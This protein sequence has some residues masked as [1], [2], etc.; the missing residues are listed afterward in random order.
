MPLLTRIWTGNHVTQSKSDTGKNRVLLDAETD[1]LRVL[2]GDEGFCMTSPSESSSSSSYCGP[3]RKMIYERCGAVAA[4]K[5][6]TS[7]SFFNGC[8]GS[9]SSSKNQKKQPSSSS[10]LRKRTAHQEE[11]LQSLHQVQFPSQYDPTIPLETYAFVLSINDISLNAIGMEKLLQASAVSLQIAR[12]LVFGEEEEEDTIV[13]GG[14]PCCNTSSAQHLRYRL[15]GFLSNDTFIPCNHPHFPHSRYH[16]H[17]DSGEQESYEEEEEKG[18]DETVDTEDDAGIPPRISNNDSS[19]SS[20]SSYFGY[21][22]N[23][24]PNG[25][26]FGVLHLLA[27]RVITIALEQVVVNNSKKRQ[28]MIDIK[29]INFLQDQFWTS[30]VDTLRNNLEMLYSDKITYYSLKCLRLLTKLEP[31]VVGQM[32]HFSLLPYLIYTTY[33]YRSN[34]KGNY[35]HRRHYNPTSRVRNEAMK[36]LQSTMSISAA[37]IRYNSLDMGS[38]EEEETTQDDKT[39]SDYDKIEVEEY[40]PGTITSGRTT[41]SNNETTSVG[42][43]SHHSLLQVISS[44]VSSV[45]EVNATEASTT[46][47]EDEATYEDEAT[48]PLENEQDK[49]ENEVD[50]TWKE[51]G[52]SNSCEEVTKTKSSSDG[53]KNT[54]TTHRIPL[55]KGLSDRSSGT[56]SSN[57][58]SGS[59]DHTETETFYEGEEE[60]E[61]E[62]ADN[63]SIESDSNS[64]I[65]IIPSSPNYSSTKSVLCDKDQETDFV[66]ERITI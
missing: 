58:S 37:T 23:T 62:D 21:D 64:S 7:Y 56:S 29:S 24:Y 47:H 27:L 41:S 57:R 26:N 55:S 30:I 36:L 20:S 6:G 66:R 42:K 13:G 35:H 65:S 16:P 52:E 32:I 17:R 59:T 43:E 31:L 11:R 2:F 49:E 39:K 12:A 5:V 22:D 15:V 34:S 45:H 63:D 25:S 53:W 4:A 3:K 40:P 54:L 60:E 1:S 38:I 61:E 46:K 33:Q 10:P 14:D 48:S 50:D 44:T 28:Q 51:E 8:S 19:S 9:R 18:E